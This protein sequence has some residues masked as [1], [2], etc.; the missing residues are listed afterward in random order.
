MI[1]LVGW[2]VANVK[3]GKS[4]EHGHGAIFYEGTLRRERRELVAS[5]L[6]SR[7]LFYT[8]LTCANRNVTVPSCLFCVFCVRVLRV[9]TLR[10]SY[11]LPGVVVWGFSS[12]DK[13]E[14][15]VPGGLCHYIDSR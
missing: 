8:I 11:I 10:L 1:W 14:I 13:L 2:L 7:L 9:S 4:G 15:E 3:G 5:L 6:T 12:L